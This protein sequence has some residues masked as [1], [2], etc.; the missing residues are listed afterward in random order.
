MKITILGLSI[1]SSWGNGHAT[2]YRALVAA[3]ASRGHEVLFL[4][5]DAEWYAHNRDLPSPPYCRTRIYDSVATLEREFSH[6]LRASDLVM[7]GS[8]VPDGIAVGDLVLRYA[9]GVT[10]FYDIDTPVTLARIDGGVDYI[11]RRQVPQYDLYLSFTGGP[12]LDL[13]RERYGAGAPRALYC[14]VDPGQYSPDPEAIAAYDLG[15]LGTFSADR[16]PTLERLM[17]RAAVL[18]PSGRFAVAGPTYPAS[19]KWPANLARVEHLAPD[20]HRGFYTRSRFTLNITRQD[21]VRA[22][23]SPSVRLFEAAACGTPII[24]DAWR[25]LE[26]FFAPVTEILLVDDARHTLAYLR[27]MPEA[28]RLAIGERARARVLSAHTSTHRAAEL[29]RYVAEITGNGSL[30]AEHSMTVGL[31][32]TAS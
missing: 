1:T 19:I 9:H 17:L 22:G 27:D 16:Q 12:T 32:R 29:E 8:Y 14:S 15:Y 25:G 11:A 24:S 26:Q 31:Q 23:Y 10:A 4:E 18:W 5:R 2:T 28:D 6:H 21:M 13:L 20:L 7:V 30:A 3:L